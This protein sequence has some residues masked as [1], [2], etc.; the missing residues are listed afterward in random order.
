MIGLADCNNFFVSCERTRN[1]SLNGRAVVVLSNNDGCVVARSN[2]AKRLGIKMGQPAFEIRD[3]VMNGE[4]IALSGN[5]L[6]YR[7]ISLKVHDIFRRYAPRTIDY[8]V[9]EAFLDMEGLPDDALVRIGEAI[10]DECMNGLAIPVTIGFAPT[11]T[12]AKVVTETCKH[13]GKRVG[14]LPD[15]P[16]EIER[17][18]KD[19]PI[20]D[21]WGIGR[22]LAKRLYIAGVYTAYDLARR[23]KVWVR[24]QMGVNGE[25]MWHELHGVS[26]I[27]LEHVGRSMQDSISET[28]TFPEDIDDYDYLRSRFAIYAAD[29]AKELR[30]MRGSAGC[31]TI[32][33]APNPFHRELSGWRP[34]AS[35]VFSSPVS[36]TV[37]I[38]KSAQMLLNSIYRPNFP[39]KRGGVILTE[40]I[41]D[42]MMDSVFD[43]EEEINRK[44]VNR[45][46]MQAVDRINP[47]AG[48]PCVRLAS[49]IT[50]G[51][52]GHND[53]YSSSFQTPKK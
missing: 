12:L 51:Q 31:I 7:E 22:R 29:C 19:I 33:L 23:D 45:K 17:I 47:R 50:C 5:H 25:K 43:S 35:H 27:E 10:A 37:T 28:R 24:A 1:A 15:N 38:V 2:E 6:L 48:H 20:R 18:L 8:S 30:K 11:K 36:D 9:D 44:T 53:G 14:L 41:P 3:K 46:L 21:V 52:V 42:R 40:I 26:C 49:Q 16:F 34:S 4:V 39:V 13:S 32:F